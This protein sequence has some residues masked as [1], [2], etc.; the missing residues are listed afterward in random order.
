MD[1]TGFG[2]E[3]SFDVQLCKNP[4]CVLIF[5]WKPTEAGKKPDEKQGYLKPG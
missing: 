5:F 3:L 1:Q 4:E 2:H